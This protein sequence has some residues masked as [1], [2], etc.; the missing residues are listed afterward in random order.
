MIHPRLG[1]TRPQY[2]PI[3]YLCQRFSATSPDR[4]P[5]TP[6]NLRHQSQ[7]THLPAPTHFG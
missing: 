1:E 6:A 7:Q 5:Q 2:F 3:R 4:S